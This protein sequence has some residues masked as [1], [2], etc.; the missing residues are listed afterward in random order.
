MIAW[1]SEPA[2]ESLVFVTVNVSAVR[3]AAEK[4][5]CESSEANVF[6]SWTLLFRRYCRLKVLTTNTAICPRVARVG[7]Q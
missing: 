3:D 4:H 1:R 2:P 7:G 6:S 5:E